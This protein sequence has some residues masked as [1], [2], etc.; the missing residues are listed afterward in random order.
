M[1][2]YRTTNW[3]GYKYNNITINGI[4]YIR[5]DLVKHTGREQHERLLPV[6]LTTGECQSPRP[7]A[8]QFIHKP[9][10]CNCRR[11]S[12]FDWCIIVTLMFIMPLTLVL[13]GYF[14]A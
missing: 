4:A 8:I 10:L 1:I 9:S 2:N 14:K 13:M 5:K 7:G 3:N 11:P 12:V 6:E